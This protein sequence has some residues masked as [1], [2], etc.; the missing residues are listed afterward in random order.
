MEAAQL[1]VGWGVDEIG[2][3]DI[4]SRGLC[5]PVH[6]YICIYFV[7]TDFGWQDNIVVGDVIV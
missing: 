2:P 1:R 6:D 7:L 5:R 3:D 4:I